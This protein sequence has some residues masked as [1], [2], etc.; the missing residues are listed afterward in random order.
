MISTENPVRTSLG[1][2]LALLLAFGILT[3][4]VDRQWAVSAVQV[5]IFA[6]TAVWLAGVALSRFELRV[7]VLLVPL[8]GAAILGCVQLIL[9][10]TIYRWATEVAVLDWFTRLSVAF[11]AMQVLGPG[12]AAR[13]HD[14]TRPPDRLLETAVWFGCAIAIV[15]VLQSFTTPDRVFWL[16]EIAP[17]AQGNTMGPFVYQNQFAAFVEILLPAALYLGLGG[18]RLRWGYL[19]A[20]GVLVS[21]VFAAVSRAGTALVIAEIVVVFVLM[22][23]RLHWRTL[24]A[25]SGAALALAALFVAAVGWG[26]LR[27]KFNRPDQLSERRL[28]YAS[29]VRMIADRPWIGSGLGTWST[30]YP[31]YATFDDGHVDNQA[32][33]E[34]L[35]W[36]AEGGLPMA[37]LMVAMA[38][39]LTVPAVRSIWGVGLLFVLVHALVDY[40]FAQRPVFGYFY[41]AMAGIL[42]SGF[43]RTLRREE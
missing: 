4:W 31:A 17:R 36:P 11:L 35:Q 18:G 33:N 24:A 42:V 1:A 37:A 20:A 26:P 16:F 15:A 9:G 28:L 29:T 6:L 21:S 8:A 41:F 27:E 19:M 23:R 39:I 2:A 38:A 14:D 7:H 43:A 34:W 13:R 30:A 25:S 12:S 40:P 5:G 22:R 32:H 10:T 3:L